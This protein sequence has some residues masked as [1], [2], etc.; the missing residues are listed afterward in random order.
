MDDVADGTMRVPMPGDRPGSRELRLEAS[1]ADGSTSGRQW[2]IEAR[3]A[4]A[5]I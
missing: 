5:A 4:E 1:H 3:H 2:L